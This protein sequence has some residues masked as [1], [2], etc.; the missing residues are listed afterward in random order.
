MKTTQEKRDS[1]RQHIELLLKWYNMDTTD[2]DF[3]LALLDDIDTLKAAL[4]QVEWISFYTSLSGI[5][6]RCPWC[7]LLEAA[8][9][10]PLCLRQLALKEGE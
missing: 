9:H 5:R 4:E 8:G 2:P 6:V 7:G 3:F 10:D 1:L